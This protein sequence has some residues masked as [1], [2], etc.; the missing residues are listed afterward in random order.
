MILTVSWRK[1]SCLYFEL[2]LKVEKWV[3]DNFNVFRLT[4]PSG[5]Y[6]PVFRELRVCGGGKSSRMLEVE[7][8]FPL[9]HLEKRQD[10]GRSKARVFMSGSLSCIMYFLMVSLPCIAV[11]F[12]LNAQIM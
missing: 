4:G 11:M 9:Q 5:M 12:L 3:N 7:E 6:P 1:R 8:H 2:Q 10:L